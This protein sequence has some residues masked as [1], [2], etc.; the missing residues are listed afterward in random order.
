M[1]ICSCTVFS[2]ICPAIQVRV[3]A[4]PDKK[5]QTLYALQVAIHTLQDYEH[6]FNTSYPLPKQGKGC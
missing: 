2:S 5:D 6:L 4:T 3:Y 1:N